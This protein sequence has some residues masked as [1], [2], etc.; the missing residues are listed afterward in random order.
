M[1]DEN[2]DADTDRVQIM[3][4]CC[5][6]LWWICLLVLLFF[7]AAPLALQPFKIDCN[8]TSETPLLRG[9]VP[10]VKMD[11]SK[12]CAQYWNCHGPLLV[13]RYDTKISQRAKYDFLSATATT[14]PMWCW[15][16]CDCVERKARE[17]KPYKPRAKSPRQDSSLPETNSW[18]LLGREDW[19]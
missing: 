2:A 3:A 13:R 17:T 4:M 9:N 8:V 18:Q 16:V 10:H 5:T 19:S 11:Y 1:P 6:S 14:R 7:T 15:M 12:N